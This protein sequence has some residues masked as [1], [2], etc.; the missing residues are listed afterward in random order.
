MKKEKQICTFNIK[1]FNK[2]KRTD[3]VRS[4]RPAGGTKGGGPH[5]R[6]IKA[7]SIYNVNIGNITSSGVTITWLTD[8][9]AIGYVEYGTTQSYGF[10]ANSAG[11]TSHSVT[12][13]NLSPSTVYNFRIVSTDLVGNAAVSSNQ[14]FQTAILIVPVLYLEFYGTTV[15]NTTWNVYGAFDVAHSGL[16]DEE[17]ATVTANIAADFEPFN[18]LVT[19]N[20]NIYNATPTSQKVKVIFTETNEWFGD[21]AGGVSYLN[22]F[23]WEDQSPSFIFTKLLGYDVHMVSEA[24][25]HE[26]GHTVG[27]R[28]QVLCQDGVKI[29]EYNPGDGVTAPIMGVSYGVPSGDWWVGPNSLGCD[30]IQDDFKAIGLKIG[31]KK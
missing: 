4:A 23:G 26:S 30:V 29:N 19:N 31:L 20:I 7:P 11:S 21:N 5:K 12:I 10:T 27:L 22:S 9:E 13:S 25:S 6:D 17:I 1:N 18:I 2:T 16:S 24:G 14:I 28:H 3:V 15:A 8:E